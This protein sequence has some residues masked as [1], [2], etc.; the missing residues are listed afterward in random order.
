MSTTTTGLT[1]TPTTCGG[2]TVY[3]IPINDAAC[4]A[5]ASKENASSAFDK[6][7]KA[8][9]VEKY[10]N[11]CGLYCLA[12]DQTIGDLVECLTSSGLNDGD[13]FCTQQN[14]RTATATSTATKTSS[15]ETSSETGSSSSSTSTSSST[16]DSEGASETSQAAAVI[17]QP[18]SKGGIGLLAMMFCSALLGVVA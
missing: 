4:A 6:C 15:S 16:S 12:L 2:A 3:D 1:T 7:C 5:T 18:V 11:D 8:A 17:N 10:D 13:V 9:P 14:N